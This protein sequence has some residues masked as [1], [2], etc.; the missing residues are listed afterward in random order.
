MKPQHFII[1]LA[2]LAG[3]WVMEL[4]APF[5]RN[6]IIGALLAIATSEIHFILR[7][8][9]KRRLLSVILT[10]FAMFILFL[11]PI[12]YFATNIAAYAQSISIADIQLLVGQMEGWVG[13][14]GEISP[15]IQRQLDTQLQ[16]LQSKE[17][18]QELL[19]YGANFGIQGAVFFKDLLLILVFY[20]FALLYGESLLRFLA[21]LTPLRE[22]DLL[23]LFYEIASVMGVVFYSIVAV[24][25]LEGI[26]FGIITALFGYDGIFLGILY[27]FSSLIPVIGGIILWI[28]V[29]L[30]EAAH[31]S[32]TNAIVILAYS[33][34]VISIIA[35][36]F[37]KPIIIGTINKKIVKSPANISEILIFFSI[38][39]GLA[40]YGFWGMILGPAITALFISALR[41]YSNL[42]QIERQG[43]SSLS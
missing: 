20:F 28:P 23:E 31:G 18:L 1:V 8:R 14:I 4:Y 13:F 41:L 25:F 32:T 35:D 38:L 30:Y 11:A 26:L 19:G 5:L 34:V 12:A 3:Y 33:I 29:A 40:T 6:I 9:L 10:T 17:V 7:K 2:I 15:E 21:T 42:M 24:A 16:T 27:G 39:A 22:A 43:D 37:L 36:T